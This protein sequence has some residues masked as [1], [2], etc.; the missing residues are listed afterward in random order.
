MGGGGQGPGLRRVP[1]GRAAGRGPGR[2]VGMK[3]VIHQ[4]LPGAPMAETPRSQRRSWDS[5]PGQA[6]TKRA[7]VLQLRASAA[8]N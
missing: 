3:E 5:I 2:G 4:G 8:N 6:T 1:G 7:C